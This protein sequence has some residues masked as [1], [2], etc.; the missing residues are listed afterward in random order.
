M[1][2]SSLITHLFC[3]T[4]I[5]FFFFFPRVRQWECNIIKS[6]LALY[7]QASGQIINYKKSCAY[8]KTLMRQ[9]KAG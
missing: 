4:T 2:G 6:C 8:F 1:M 5:G 3:S 9:R 7:E